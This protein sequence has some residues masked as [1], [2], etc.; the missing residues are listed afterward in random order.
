MNIRLKKLLYKNEILSLALII[1]VS[2]A[3]GLANPA[4][5]DIINIF[6]LLKMCAYPAIF[7]CGVMI[8]L[9]S[10]GI[11][12]SFMW[13]GMFA[14]YSTSK[15]LSIL[16]IEA[17]LVMPLPLIFLISILIGAVLGFSGG[18]DGLR[19]AVHESQRRRYPYGHRSSAVG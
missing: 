3:F 18:W 10:G 17:G 2:V 16:Q 7:A 5:F 19:W 11:D 12:M 4:F 15:L 8:V 6:D 9:I 13:I 1:V 14:A